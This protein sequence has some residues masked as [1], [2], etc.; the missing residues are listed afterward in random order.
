MTRSNV[1][2]YNDQ[3]L[4]L[5]GFIQPHGV[6]MSLKSSNLKVLQVSDNVSDVLNI[7]PEDCLDQE[8]SQFLNNEDVDKIQKYIN[9]TTNIPLPLKITVNNILLDAIIHRNIHGF[10]IL[11]LEPIKPEN[12]FDLVKFYHDMRI[13]VNKIHQASNIEEM[14][15]ILVKQLR[16]MLNFERILVYKY[17]TD[18]HGLVIAEDKEEEIETYLGLHYPSTDIPTPARELYIKNWVRYIPNMDYQPARIIS[19]DDSIVK[20]PLDLTFSVLRGVSP[21]HI[22]YM[23]NWG[24]KTSMSISLLKQ[25]ELWG[26]ITFHGYSQKYIPYEIRQACEFIGHVMSLELL[27]KDDQETYEYKLSL[28]DKVSKLVKST[29]ENDNLVEGLVSQPQDFLQLT[30]ATGGVICLENQC[31]SIGKIPSASQLKDLISWIKSNTMEQIFYTDSLAKY[32]YPQ[33]EEIKEVASGILTMCLANNWDDYVIWF[34]PQE[35]QEVH[36]AGNPFYSYYEETDDNGDTKLCPRKSF[37]IWKEQVALKSFPWLTCEI[38]AVKDLRNAIINVILRKANEI[39]ELAQELKRTNAELQ[40]FAYV[41]S[42]DLQE[43]LNQVISYVQLLEMRYQDK[44]DDKANEFIGFA[45]DGVTQM[46]QL[47]DDLLEYSRLGSRS[48]EFVSVDLNKV[49]ARVLNN[50]K[51]KIEDSQG[52]ID[53]DSL[54]TVNGDD[55]QLMQLWQN[56]ITNA[57]KFRAD[58]APK[59]KISVVEKDQFWLFSIQDNGIGME[60]EFCDRIFVIFQRLHTR[61]KYPGTGIGLTICKRIVERHNGKIWVESELNKGSTFYFTIV[62]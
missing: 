22:E 31:Q 16:K 60:P 21:C 11:E 47:I 28:K 57:L 30:N 45:V 19:I 50:L 3:P 29:S 23:K 17:D 58:K 51:I 43:P 2:L 52:E 39:T 25:N 62:K 5:L 41:A 7:L 40:Q 27:A 10:F 32:N 35:I 44:L 42:H 12:N 9:E 56:L 4:H 33:A 61:N 49:I 34:R 53:Y 15:G 36:W 55:T 18:W 54:P 46:Q 20:M 38:G 8:I 48:K 6:L 26:L 59:I 1:P 14:S 24:V 13:T 37:E